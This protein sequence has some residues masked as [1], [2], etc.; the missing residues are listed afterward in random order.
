MLALQNEITVLLRNKYQEILPIPMVLSLVIHN[1]FSLV[2]TQKMYPTWNVIFAINIWGNI[3]FN[4]NMIK[5]SNIYVSI[6]FSLLLL[7]FICWGMENIQHSMLANP[8]YNNIS[9]DNYY[10]EIFQT[11]M[12]ALCVFITHSLTLVYLEVRANI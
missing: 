6:I 7:M 1:I 3:L 2:Y 9:I 10:Q 12:L 4:K 5:L 11:F 8:E